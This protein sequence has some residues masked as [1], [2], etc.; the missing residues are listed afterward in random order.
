MPENLNNKYE[1]TLEEIQA[2]LNLLNSLPSTYQVL[3]GMGRENTLRLAQIFNI[4]E[5]G[6]ER[7]KQEKQNQEIIK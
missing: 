5:M 2:I 1:Y 4:L 3:N 6:V 7:K